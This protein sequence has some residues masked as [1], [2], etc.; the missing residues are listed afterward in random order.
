MPFVEF[1]GTPGS[2]KSTLM[3]AVVAQLRKKRGD[4]FL[5]ADDALFDAARHGIDPVF[6][7]P[8]TLLPRPVAKAFFTKIGNRSYWQLDG[9]GRFLAKNDRIFRDILDS[10][11]FR[12]LSL[13]EKEI[14]LSGFQ[15]AGGAY[16]CIRQCSTQ[17]QYIFFDEGLLQKSMMFVAP[18][19]ATRDAAALNRYLA[20]VPLPDIAVVLDLDQ[21]RCRERMRG[22]SK[23]LI[24]RLQGDSPDAIEAFLNNAVR[25]WQSIVDWL[26]N[27]S[28]TRVVTL[29]SAARIE[30]TTT[31]V[32]DYILKDGGFGRDGK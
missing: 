30:M 1:V 11:P 32:V 6:K 16:E 24:R 13:A 17:E 28:A 22:R 7:I 4:L 8:L 23:G 25:H 19:A 26:E 9:Q 20:A 18:L 21:K 5:T 31:A 10:E 29:S 27:E 2:G 15:Q 12:S 3:A 14:V